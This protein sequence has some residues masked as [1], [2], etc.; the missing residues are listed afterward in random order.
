MRLQLAIGQ[1]AGG[2]V[3][4]P[5]LALLVL[6][7]T[8]RHGWTVAAGSVLGWIALVS[9]TAVT[10]YRQAQLRRPIRPQVAG[11]VGMAG[12]G[13]LACTVSGLWP[14][15]PEWGYRTLMLGWAVY[16]LLVVLA[17]WWVASVQTLPGAQG[18]PQALV[19]AASGWVIASGVAAVLLGLKAAFLHR[20]DEE[21]LWGAAAIAVAATAGAAMAMW[22]RREGWAF[23]AAPGVNVAASLVVWYFQRPPWHDIAFAEWWVLLVQANVIATAAVALIW[24]AAWKRLYEL[25][26]FSIRTSPLLAAQTTLG[27][28]ALAAVLIPAVARAVIEPG[29]LPDWAVQLASPVGWVALAMVAAAAGWYLFQASPRDLLHVAGCLA[30]GIGVLS[31]GTAAQWAG[32]AAIPW[33]SYHTLMVVWA[34]GAAAILLV[35]R[36]ARSIRVARQ[37]E[38]GQVLSAEVSE[39]IAPA[40]LVPGWVTVIGVLTLALALLH[41]HHDPAAPWWSA[42]VILGLSVTAGLVAMW[43]RLPLYVA[44][45]GVLV[46]VAGTVLWMAWGP[47]NGYALVEANIVCLAVGAGIWSLIQM[48]HPDGEAAFKIGVLGETFARLAAQLA[49][50]LMAA[51]AMVYMVQAAGLWQ[52]PTADRLAWLALAATAV[53]LLV[54]LWDRSAGFV[55]PGL[56][57]LGLAAIA[58]ALDARQ[59]ESMRL[60]WTAAPELAGFALAAAAAGWLLVR[61]QGTWQAL[62]IPADEGRWPAD[63]FPALQAAVAGG[64]A[65]L[66]AWIAIDLAFDP[67]VHPLWSRLAGR[68]AGPLAG[69]IA[70]GAAVATTGLAERRWRTG[71]QYAALALG[72]LALGELGWAWLPADLKLPWLHR[73]VVLMVAAVAATLVASFGIERI[74]RTGSDWI[75]AGRRGVPVLAGIGL[76]AFLAV[77]LQE[78]GYYFLYCERFEAVPMAMAA[79]LIVVAALAGLFVGCLVLALVPRLDPFR[80]SERG[81]TVY[82]YLAEVLILLVCLHLRWTMPD[83]FRLEIMRKYWMLM[84]MGVAFAGAGLS[85]LFQRR[86]MPVLSEPLERTAVLLPLAP[87]LFFFFVPGDVTDLLGLAGASPAVWFLGGLFYGV[88]AVTKRKPWSAALAVVAMNVGLWVLWQR[89]ELHFADRP[90]LWLIPA[91]LCLLVAEYLNHERLSGAQ[92]AAARYFALCT[93][94][95]SSSAEYLPAVGRSVWLPLILVLL[96]LVGI[97]AGVVL[98][99]RS[100][101]YMGITFLLVVIVTMIRWAYVDQHVTWI[102]W[103]CLI[104]LGL[105]ILT[106]VGMYERRRDRIVAVVKEFRRWQR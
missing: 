94:Y 65:V 11:V 44:C 47:W 10:V 100:F 49:L 38:S 43:H 88:L 58:V 74:A 5:A 87:A 19:R 48:A 104:L 16:A 2:L 6:V 18:P 80:L 12:L 53:A 75:D 21:I 35:G 66:G 76:A 3:L 31:M 71:W 85:E 86:R 34:A 60:A 45:S 72:T 103:V 22:R 55:L 39:P 106:A 57:L 36:L 95:V 84:V 67:M 81:R 54:L 90:Q 56:Y 13:L 42:G 61:M 83:L 7:P 20:L 52:H 98:R 37:S 64:A 23:A 32:T 41:A 77:L 63:W 46:N 29:Q 78:A 79:K 102:L 4:V 14:D 105:A 51:V 99:I 93:I 33:I 91:A 101:L 1:A 92:S 70:L 50:I 97:F 25:R 73:S 8:V 28:A 59:L 82:V 15:A 40:E 24:L 62:G 17:T 27:A 96:S 30:L 69:V 26:A 89:H 9:V 68:P